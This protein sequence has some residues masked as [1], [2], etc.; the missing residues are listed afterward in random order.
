MKLKNRNQL[1]AAAMTMV[2]FTFSATSGHAASGTWTGAAGSGIWGGTGNWVGSTVADGSGFTASFTSEFTS[3][4][5]CTV[6]TARTI[7]NITFTDTTP[8]HDLNLN[9]HASNFV[10]T[11][12][13]TTPTINVTQAGRTV[14]INTI[15][16]GTAG[17]TKSGLGNL[18]LTNAGNTYTGNTLITGGVLNASGAGKISGNTTANK[19]ALQP[20]VAGNSAIVNYSSSTTSSLFAVVGANIA[21]TA[22]VLNQSNGTI[23]IRPNTTTDTQNVVGVAGAYG[24]YNISGGTFLN[25]TGT[26]GGSRF[27]LTNIGT[28][29]A[30]NG[31]ITGVRVGLLNVSGTGFIDHTNAEW[32]LNY[33]LAKST[34][35]TPARSTTPA[36]TSHLASS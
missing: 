7:G 34:S 33:S 32:W 18:T 29:S 27:T 16:A 11:L 12:A 30:T 31:T 8:T 22:S 23:Q 24:V 20:T 17:I 15:T 14:T 1:L 19:L 9:L 13:G 10:L 26:A 5:N 6:N 25:S 3:T 2:S 28:A 21:G 36:A 4:Q 35:R